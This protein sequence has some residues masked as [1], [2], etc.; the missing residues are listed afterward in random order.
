MFDPQDV[1]LSATPDRNNDV[2]SRSGGLSMGA[3]ETNPDFFSTA[4]KRKYTYTHVYFRLDF[5]CFHVLWYYVAQLS[6]C[7]FLFFFP[8][9]F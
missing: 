9:S 4:I 7:F 2:M 1:L 3:N 5:C 6:A 8:K